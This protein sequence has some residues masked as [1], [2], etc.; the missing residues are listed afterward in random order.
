MRW[1]SDNPMRVG[2]AGFGTVGRDLARRLDGG[3]IPAAR[4]TAISARDLEKAGAA[5]RDLAVP[6][7]VVPVAELPEHADTIVECA[8]GE[9]LSE[10]ATA[11]LGAGKTLIAV[12]VGA[13]AAQPEI[14]DLAEAHGGRLLIATGALP[15]LDSIRAAAEGEI[16]FVKLT[17]RVRPDSL[18]H[19]AY[20]LDK[21]FD[22]TRP[23][24]APV[25]VFEGTAGEAAAAFP[26]HF[27]VA[28]TLSLAGIGFDKTQVEVWADAEIQ[29]AV[30]RIQ[31]DAADISL[32][33][34]SRNRPSET[35]PRTS[36]AVAPSIMATLRSLV[37]PVRIGN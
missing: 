26:R 17:S 21:G 24:E 34:E 12:S 3:A 25:K 1:T 5:S 37:A 18:V 35:N 29:G 9:A 30:H 8:T 36:R 7:K 22:L 2:L 16:R 19:E 33:L 6:P 4:L 11:A 27:N 13:I 14:L 23:L 32:D 15:G 20:I 10:I 28:V 31:V